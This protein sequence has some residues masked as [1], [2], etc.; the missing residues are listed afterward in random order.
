MMNVIINADDLGLSQEVN[1]AT[2][3]LMSKRIAT[4]ATIMSNGPSVLSAIEG[5][6]RFPACSF[7]VHLNLTEFRPLSRNEGL[8]ELLGEDGEFSGVLERAPGSIKKSR[9]LLFA[10][11]DEWC[12]Q[13]DFLQKAGVQ[14]SHLDSHQH[15]HTIPFVFPVLKYVQAKYGIRRVRATRNVY[16]AG[17]SPSQ[18]MLWA[19]RA[20]QFSLR[21]FYTTRTTHVFMDFSTFYERAVVGQ[22]EWPSVEVMVHPGSLSDCDENQLLC[23]SWQDRL[24]GTIRMINYHDV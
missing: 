11:A 3:D 15:V 6:K 2:F 22:Q 9:T 13:I 24:T 4:S 20:Y 7:G 5:S 19:K 12:H 10:M 14:V 17:G 1:E 21:H 23:S 18:V 16:K 8:K